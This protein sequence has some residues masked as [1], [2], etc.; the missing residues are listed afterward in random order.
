MHIVFI[1]GSGKRLGKKLAIEFAKKGWDIAIHY[2][3]SEIEANITEQEISYLGV[4]CVK[5]QADLRNEEEI[6]RSFDYIVES[7]GVPDVLINN[8]GIYPEQRSL[9]DIETDFWEDVIRI[10]T[11]SQ[12]LMSKHFS[13]I[14]NVGGR[15]I[16]IASL[17]GQEIWNK[18]LAYNVSK[19]ASL[20]LTKGLAR[21]LAP[22]ISVNS[23]SPGIVDIEDDEPVEKINISKERIPMKRYASYKDVFDAVYFFAICSQYITA[24][25]I[26][27]DGGF[28]DAR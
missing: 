18:R 13:K 21:E 3:S 16:N 27:I 19:S 20:T 5:V 11:S 7:L 8:A 17:G 25:N 2:N 12:M 1:T 22:N 23:V 4:N 24:Q 9:N 6:K 10:N 15:I 28:H 14:A 26:N